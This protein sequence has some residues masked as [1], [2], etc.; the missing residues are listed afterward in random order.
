[1]QVIRE[2]FT[3]QTL[4]GILQYMMK[5]PVDRTIHN[6]L[7]NKLKA[8]EKHFGSDVVSYSGPIVVVS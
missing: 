4:I 1:M 6:L 7:T 2:W 5:T 8:L 3:T